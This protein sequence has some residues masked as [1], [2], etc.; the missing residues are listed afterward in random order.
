ML[1]AS[2]SI[3]ATIVATFPPGLAPTGP[4]RRTFWRTR[5]RSPHCSASRITGSSPAYE[6]RRWS[7]K[8]ASTAPG[9][10]NNRIS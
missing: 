2:V 9:V 1:S 3:P 8:T 4:G 10:C 6:I 5:C 7:S